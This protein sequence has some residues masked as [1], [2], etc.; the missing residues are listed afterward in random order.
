V[1]REPVGAV[2]GE[3]TGKH[4]SN[5]RREDGCSVE[6][7]ATPSAGQSRGQVLDG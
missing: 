4:A 2:C 5:G 6:A 1:E 3:A 7:V